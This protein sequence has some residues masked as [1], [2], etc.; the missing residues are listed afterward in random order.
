MTDP[1]AD[2]TAHPTAHPEHRTGRCDC[3]GVRYRVTGPMRGVV[4][5]HC[6]RC[7]RIT[8]HFMAASGAADADLELAA[9]ETLRWYEPASGVF[10]GFC[11]VCGSTLFYRNAANPG[12]TSVAAGTLD[13]PTGLSTTAAWWTAEASDYHV[14]DPTVTGYERES[15]AVGF[16]A[17]EG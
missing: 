16:D 9:A 10:Y 13:L 1:T 12:W 6:P 4:N 17:G 5:C 8:G 14:L 3:G 15:G 11:S 2:P 7:R